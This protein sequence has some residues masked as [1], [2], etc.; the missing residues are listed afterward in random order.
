[1]DVWEAV[2]LGDAGDDIGVCERTAV[3]S[4]AT[5]GVD[6]DIEVDLGVGGDGG[7]DGAPGRGVG[8]GV[9]V[10]REK[11]V[12]RGGRE[13]EDVEPEETQHC[14]DRS[15]CGVDTKTEMP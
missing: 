3:C 8:A 15:D 10:E 5:V 12:E 2:E 7:E 1:M 9:E 13:G 6:H 4:R 14:G 11:D